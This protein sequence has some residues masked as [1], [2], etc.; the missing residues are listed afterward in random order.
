MKIYNIVYRP[1]SFSSYKDKDIRNFNEMSVKG[2]DCNVKDN[3]VIRGYMSADTI[4]KNVV[5]NSKNA[6]TGNIEDLNIHNLMSIGESSY[7]GSTLANNLCAVELLKNSDVTTVVDLVGYKNLEKECNKNNIRYIKYPVESDYWSNP[8]FEN[9]VESKEKFKKNLINR[10][11]PG[12]A[13]ED[14][15]EDF[16]THEL[17]IRRSDVNWSRR[18]FMED[19]INLI[20]VIQDGH[21]YIGCEYGEF[22]T[23]NI[24]AMNTYFNPKWTGV[25]TQP[26]DETFKEKMKNMY[27]NMVEDEKEMLGFTE[28]FEEK[29]KEEFNI[30]D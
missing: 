15:P 5:I 29:L 27:V 11:Y 2:S 23:P 28:A 16:L 20:N 22:R 18:M 17:R 13:E 10:Y 30:T 21:F 12:M 25:K 26:T 8:I 14:I 9:E 4:T 3:N 6:F 1:V 7:R 19:F 24:L